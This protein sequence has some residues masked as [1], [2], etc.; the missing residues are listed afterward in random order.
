MRQAEFDLADAE[1][2]FEHGR[3]ALACFLCQQA[4]EK[5]VASFLFSRG[6]EAVWGHAL[7]DLCQDAVALEPSFELIA[8][9]A[10]LLDKYYLG[11]RYPSGLPGGVPA[12]AF[13]AHD[14]VRALEIARDVQTFV[15]GFTREG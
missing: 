1:L 15:L 9:V 8:T 2:A 13:D 12:E 11:T 3:H 5:A 14:S 6:A 4:A 7:A 10:V